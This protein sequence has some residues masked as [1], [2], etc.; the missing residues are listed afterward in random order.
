MPKL[1]KYLLDIYIGICDYSIAFVIAPLNTYINVALLQHH[2]HIYACIYIIY[3]RNA[4][5]HPH[6]DKDSS[7]EIL[8]GLFKWICIH[9]I[10]LA[11]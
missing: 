8:C 1:G 3:C 4:Y 11:K 5:E 10:I 7:R 2:I 6:V 9:M